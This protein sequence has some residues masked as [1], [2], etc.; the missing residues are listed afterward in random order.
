MLRDEDQAGETY[1]SF[2][3]MKEVSTSLSSSAGVPRDL[4]LRSM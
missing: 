2:G 3:N 1:M 4:S